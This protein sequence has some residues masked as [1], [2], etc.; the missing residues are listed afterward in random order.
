MLAFPP[1]RGSEGEISHGVGVGI[2]VG[3]GV[4]ACSPWTHSSF[5]QLRGQSHR[6]ASMTMPVSM[7]YPTRMES[8]QSSHQQH[9]PRNLHTYT[10]RSPHHP[11][12]TYPP[13]SNGA[14][15]PGVE[16][17]AYSS[18]NANYDQ[19]PGHAHRSAPMEYL[20]S[21]PRQ[22]HS[23]QQQQKSQGH[24]RYSSGRSRQ[25]RPVFLPPLPPSMPDAGVSGY[26]PE[27]AGNN[28]LS[29]RVHRPASMAYPS[30]PLISPQE[31]SQP[32]VGPSYHARCTHQSHQSR[33]RDAYP[34]PARHADLWTD[35]GQ[36]QVPSPTWDTYYSSAIDPKITGGV[37]PAA[38]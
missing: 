29:G 12:L 26:D 6:P 8:L 1:L 37:L 17:G 30:P 23:P 4:G 21:P 38:I 22:P 9:Q 5:E 35:Q 27:H 14:I 18:G 20:P 33:Q 10:S 28:Q 13:L 24:H 2:G 11:V 19:L 36:T 7:P 34:A 31:H 16:T 32:Q 15:S 25:T 3:I